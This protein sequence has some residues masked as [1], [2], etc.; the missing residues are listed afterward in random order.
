MY[1]Q[2]Q[3]LSELAAR[4]RNAAFIEIQDV[5]RFFGF[6]APRRNTEIIGAFFDTEI[7]PVP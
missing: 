5:F 7:K 6:F 2:L 3:V 4:F 1:V